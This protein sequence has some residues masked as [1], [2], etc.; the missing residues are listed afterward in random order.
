MNRLKKS[1]E[2][3]RKKNEIKNQI[4]AL[5]K[6]GKIEEAHAL[7][8]NLN[9]VSQE[10]EVAITL[11]NEE[12][13]EVAN[14]GTEITKNTEKVDSNVVFNKQLNGF[15]LTE[16]EREYVSN[17]PGSPG[18]IEHDDERGGV[19]V[20]EESSN[21][22]HEFRRAEVALKDYVNVVQVTTMSG[23]FPVATEQTGKL[24]AFEELTEI[25]QSQITFTQQNWMVKDYGD[26]IPVSNTLL[27]DVRVNLV[28]FIGRQFAKK[29]VNTENAEILAVLKSMTTGSTVAGTGIADVKEILNITLDPAISK[30]AKIFTNQSGFN[31]LDNLMDTTGR[32]LLSLSLTKEGTKELNTRE[33][34]VLPDALLANSDSGAFPFYIGDLEQ[35]VNFYDRIGI[36]VSKSEHAGFTKNA[37]LLRVVERFD[38]K[39]FDTGA[40]AYMELTPT[41]SV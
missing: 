37:T 7:I 39:P 2:L 33:V 16:A 35:A 28:N 17:A 20:P 40:V 34:V 22:I 1:I 13:E 27:Q 41:P 26:I 3:L 29:A 32:P 9:K 19:L 10:L 38:V 15:A 18:Q 21:K 30:S 8:E 4:E 25:Q 5:Q 12:V 23:K 14:K 31:Y 24:V 36:E 6:E 11:E